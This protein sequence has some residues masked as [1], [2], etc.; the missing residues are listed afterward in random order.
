M[1]IYKANIVNRAKSEAPLFIRDSLYTN[2][3]GA[4]ELEPLQKNKNKKTE[5]PCLI[6]KRKYLHKYF[7]NIKNQIFLY[8]K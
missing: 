2:S 3:G 1:K 4:R 8:V 7:E 5:A 6:L